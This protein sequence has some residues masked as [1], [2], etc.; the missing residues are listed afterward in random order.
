MTPRRKALGKGLDALIPPSE[1]Q[2]SALEIPIASLRPNP[3]Q[4]RGELDEAGLEELASSIK[5]NGILQP[6][7]VRPVAPDK[8]QVVAGQRRV[9]AARLAGLTAV[10]AYVRDVPNDKLLTVALIENLQ[11]EDINPIEEAVAY[12]Y[13]HEDEGMS[14]EAIARAIGKHRATVTNALRLLNLSEAVTEMLRNGEIT[15]GHARALLPLQ[16]P[17]RQ[18]A[19]AE[20][21][22]KEGMSVR[23]VENIVSPAAPKRKSKKR[24]RAPFRDDLEKRIAETLATKVK[25]TG[26]NKK[27]SITLYFYNADDLEKILKVLGVKS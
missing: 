26:S 18:F 2:L 12:K 13:L 22:V 23:Q 14:H 21:I 20:R 6:I 1:G 27:G 16:S 17:S 10:P 7:L 11:R 4:P 15:S 9:E 5:E 25:V 24:K 19:L 8:Y 3:L